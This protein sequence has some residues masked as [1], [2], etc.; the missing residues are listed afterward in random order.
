MCPSVQVIVIYHDQLASSY[1]EIWSSSAIISPWPNTSDPDTCLRFLRHVF[2]DG[3]LPDKF[4]VC[5]GEL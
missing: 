3:K 5:Q 4:V 1:P 2:D